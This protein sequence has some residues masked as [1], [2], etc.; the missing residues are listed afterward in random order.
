[1]TSPWIVAGL[2]FLA[3]ALVIVAL[4]LLL[5]RWTEGRRQRV[6]VRRLQPG[7]EAP[8]GK[9]DAPLAGELFR[10]RPGETRGGLDAVFGRFPGTA[11]L[12]S[13]LEQA[14]GSWT[15]MKFV[16]AT[17]A[18]GLVGGFAG[19]AVLRIALLAVAAGVFTATWPYLWVRRK[20]RQRLDAFEQSF[21]EA[22]DLLGRSI[23][24]GHA[25]ST[26]LQM[27]ADESPDPVGSEFRQVFEE[28]R[29]GLP[30]EDALLG[31]TDRV[32]LVDVRI[33]TTAVLIQRE[34]GG[35]LAEILDSLA[36]TIRER[37]TIQRQVR[38]YTAQGRFTG[39]LLAVLPFALGLVI[40]LLNPE[41]MSVLWTEATGRLL[42]GLALMLQV[43][44]YFVIRRIVDIEI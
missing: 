40:F 33:F 19:F 35:N 6:V 11:D 8:A 43:I 4:S 5:D 42:M 10:E 28:H 22:I 30:L 34:V 36:G 14:G 32:E 20:K 15:P 16:G 7:S 38:V 37:F 39:Y 1:M 27:V 31:L 44:G 41:Y 25:F 18:A 23:R 24:A 9:G 2:V 26:G 29:F 21:P 12:R 3:G 17:L 13:L